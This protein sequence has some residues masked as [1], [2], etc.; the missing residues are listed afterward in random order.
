MSALLR[1]PLI[2]LKDLFRPPLIGSL[3]RLHSGLV[4]L[5]WWFL[6]CSLTLASF[7]LC[8]CH[9]P[10]SLSALPNEPRDTEVATVEEVGVFTGDTSTHNP[11]Y[12][13]CCWW[14]SGIWGRGAEAEKGGSRKKTS[15]TIR[16]MSWHV[17][18]FLSPLVCAAGLAGFPILPSFVKLQHY[19][20]MLN[21]FENWWKCFLSLLVYS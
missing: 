9:S 18:Y 6:S 2:F 11:P 10:P 19:L 21:V 8:C 4:V 15:E 20:Q 1:I 5:I 14:T 7:P 16:C 13:L 17:S 3:R 12:Q